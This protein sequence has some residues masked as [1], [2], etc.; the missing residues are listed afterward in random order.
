ML[1]VVATNWAK[2]SQFFVLLNLV[3]KSSPQVLEYAKARGLIS[4]LVGFFLDGDSP[5][6]QYNVAQ[7][8]E[9]AAASSNVVDYTDVSIVRMET[10]CVVQV[11]ECAVRCRAP[12]QPPPTRRLPTKVWMMAFE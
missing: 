3:V 6:P 1:P 7:A 12:C 2:M 5:L 11:P 8:P 9:Y 10:C 4:V